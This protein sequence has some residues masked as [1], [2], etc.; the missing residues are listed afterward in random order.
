MLNKKRFGFFFQVNKHYIY[1]RHIMNCVVK[2][3]DSKIPA[4][5]NNFLCLL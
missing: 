2:I 1:V 3:S 4:E 5:N